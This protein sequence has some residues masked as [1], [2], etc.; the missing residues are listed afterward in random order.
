MLHGGNLL[1]CCSALCLCFWQVKKIIT[2][3]W[4]R[5][6]RLGRSLAIFKV[7]K[8]PQVCELFFMPREEVVRTYKDKMPKNLEW[9]HLYNP[10][11]EVAFWA[12]LYRPSAKSGR[13]SSILT[14]ELCGGFGSRYCIAEGLLALL[15]EAGSNG[16]NSQR[17]LDKIRQATNAC[18][19]EECEEL[20]AQAQSKLDKKRR[21]KARQKEKKAAERA[22]VQAE[23]AKQRAEEDEREQAA[24]KASKIQIPDGALDMSSLR[25]QLF[26]KE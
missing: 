8:Q 15:D 20:T 6:Q 16:P 10:E 14:D 9:V 22:Q 24:V 18:S 19:R 4:S 23:E 2:P 11:N 13:G 26:N 17:A 12:E 25:S 5:V 7:H 21:K 3:H 1:T